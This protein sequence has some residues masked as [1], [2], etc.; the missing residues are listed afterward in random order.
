MGDERE[1]QEQIDEGR[2]DALVKL[3]KFAIYT[4]PVVSA[5]LVSNKATAQSC[6]IVHIEVPP[7]EICIG[8]DPPS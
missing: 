5:L 2:R 3:G 1:S 8:G 6:T 7:F 4:A